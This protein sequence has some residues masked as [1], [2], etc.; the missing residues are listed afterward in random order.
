MDFS[1]DFCGR[2]YFVLDMNRD[3]NVTIS[4]L[5][6]LSRNIFL[7]PSKII[8]EWVA[9]SPKLATFFEIDCFTGEHAGGAVVSLFVWL[10]VWTIT[11][12]AVRG[13]LEK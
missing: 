10:A 13:Y 12:A 1:N 7:I 6:M 2:F 11:A 8:M 3:G 4:D 9:S 5:W